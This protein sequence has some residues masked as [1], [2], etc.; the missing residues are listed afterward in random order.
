MKQTVVLTG[1]G[2]AGHVTPLLAVAKALLNRQPTLRI[3]YIGQ[4]GDRN[5]SVIQGSSLPIEIKKIWAGKYRRYHGQ[6]KLQRLFD[7]KTNLLNVRDIFFTTFGILEAFVLIA[8]LRPDTIFTKGG[9]ASIPACVAG[10]ILGKRIVSHDS[11]AVPGLANRIIGRFVAIHAVATP[12]DYPYPPEKTEVVG[13]PVQPE[14]AEYAAKDQADTR[15]QIG[16][17]AD[18]RVLFIGG[19]TQGARAIDDAI[20][21]VVP[22]L[23]EKDPNL[24]VVQVFGRLNEASMTGRYQDI[25]E[26]ISARLH[27]Y[28]FLPDNYRYFAAADVIVSRAGAT[29]LAEAA[30]QS[31]ACLIIPAPQLAEGHQLENAESLQAAGAAVVLHEANLSIAELSATIT[32]LLNDKNERRKLGEALHKTVMI[33]AAD[34]LAALILKDGK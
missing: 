23:L 3:V 5:I 25:D 21:Q 10:G 33:D 30:T 1:G 29:F 27:R 34:K 4:R 6:S 32:R 24:E 11:D 18:S 15:K 8:R 13:I 2:T 31:R 16:L 20:E 7:V 28:T 14:Y 17:P 22:D 9:F 19:S 26:K 12:G